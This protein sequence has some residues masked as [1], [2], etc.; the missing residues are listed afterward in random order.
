MSL[1]ERYCP[2]NF[3]EIVGNKKVYEN[4]LK[5]LEKSKYKGKYLLYGKRGTG[6][7]NFVKILSK[8][9]KMKITEVKMIDIQTRGT[10]N[11]GSSNEK[12]TK[13]K[14]LFKKSIRKKIIL[15]DG[16]D[17]ATNVSSL[18]NPIESK[19]K[20]L[21]KFINKDKNN[22]IFIISTENKKSI[23][24]QYDNLKSFG[25]K[26]I[27]DKTLVKFVKN[28]LKKENKELSEK[29]GDTFIKK[30]VKNSESNIRK[31]LMDLDLLTQDKKKVK[32]SENNKQLLGKN[33]ND[34]TYNN[35]YELM[36]A[37]LKPCD[38]NN[39]ENLQLKENIY[40][41]D[42]FMVG[43]ASFEYYLKGENCKNDV[44]ILNKIASSI[45]DG[46]VLNGMRRD[47]DFS[48]NKYIAYSE[49]MKPTQLMGKVKSQIFFPSNVS[50]Q[51]KVRNNR[52]KLA[53]IKSTNSKVM[54]YTYN[55]FMYLY[56]LEKISKIKKKQ[57]KINHTLIKSIFT[58]I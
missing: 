42:T 5:D 36:S 34:K 57:Q 53:A 3:K 37:S 26:K 52:K 2:T 21:S 9:K 58:I 41:A 28:V 27:M 24:K 40:W 30:L 18:K 47:C 32:F 1:L 23:F 16:V 4:I 55:E 51:N 8:L 54:D 17:L 7:T 38:M 13:I 44:N 19:L 11:E 50:K 6:K 29:T 46:D 48:I 12:N 39:P 35:I 25:L 33:T 10:T 15:I 45:A 56:K 49:Y 43:A 20:V 31:I 22:L 14:Y